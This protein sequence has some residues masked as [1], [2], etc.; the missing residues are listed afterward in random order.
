M[1]SAPRQ[2]YD[3]QESI[4]SHR[5]TQHAQD[6]RKVPLPKVPTRIAGLDDI[7]A[8]GLP[9]SRTTVISGGPGC[10]K[11]ILSL[12]FI[13]RGAL[14]GEPGIFVTFEESIQA[15]QQNALTMGWD[16]QDLVG[17]GKLFLLSAS[18][19]S[20]LFFSGG[21][22]F[23]GMLAI[24]EGLSKEM[25]AKRIV[26]DALDVLL[27]FS[28]NPEIERNELY[29]LHA[30]LNRN[31]LTAILTSKAADVD[32]QPK[33]YDFLDYMADC[34]IN[35][36]QRILDQVTTR[37]LR[38][39]KYRG[40]GFGR[41]E[42]PYVITDDGIN[43]VP[44]SSVTLRHQPLGER[45]P[46]GNDGFDEVLGGGFRRSACI[47]VAGSTG[48]GKT[49]FA[50]TFINAACQRGERAVFIGFEESQ[51]AVIANMRS[52]GIELTPAV[53]SGVLRFITSQPEALGSEEHLVRILGE[54]KSFSPE[55]VVLDAISACKRM[56]S[57]QA[58]FDFIIRL[59]NYCKER[60]ITCM[61]VNQTPNLSDIHEA[62]GVDISSII[63]TVIYLG[64]VIVGGEI[65]RTLLVVKSRGSAHSN[66]YR[67]FKIT[68]SGL[69]ISDIY[70]GEGGVLT[71]A[72]RQEQEAR[73]ALEVRRR[74]LSIQLKELEVARMEVAMREQAS[75]LRAELDM[76]KMQLEALR[77]DER[78]WSAE[79]DVRH[80][81][82]EGARKPLDEDG[83]H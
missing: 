28:P 39:R 55:C 47:L 73:D 77:I 40:S 37:R 14:A 52:C 53:D 83:N 81:L 67:E 18:Q 76:A 78:A 64:M 3:L 70:V 30:C 8:G 43:I 69:Q 44:V 6:V 2:P 1:Q 7:L 60:N 33:R 58:A 72:A 63:D 17:R 16:L 38:V 62:S 11:S 48:A 59:V 51:E 32:S 19:D 57:E 82:R 75:T 36:D 66:Q 4:L 26:L 29:S 5:S 74:E 79:R 21:Y 41:N 22:D 80:T 20:K 68:N 42:Y 12:E 35:L 13:Y 24:L 71:G 10:G 9:E 25:G 23:Q 15:V 45:I 61:M 46:S 34:V 56:G 49:S 54:I 27:R 31:A 65:N 50:A